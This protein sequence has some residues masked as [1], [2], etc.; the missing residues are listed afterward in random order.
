M[1]CSLQLI[2]RIR[3][4]RQGYRVPIL[5]RGGDQFVVRGPDGPRP[6]HSDG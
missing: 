1:D 5:R 3:T 4:Y 6:R 2:L